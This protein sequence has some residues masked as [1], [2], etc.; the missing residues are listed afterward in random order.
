MPHHRAAPLAG[1]LLL[2]IGLIVISPV[3]ADIIIDEE[4]VSR[5]DTSAAYSVAYGRAIVH[6]SHT[7][8]LFFTD[9][10]RHAEL[11]YIVITR[12]GGDYGWWTD[13]DDLLAEGRHEFE[14]EFNG[15][16]RPGVLY[17]AK[18]RNLY[19]SVTKTE[20]TIFLNDW[21]ISGLT[22]PQTLTLPF[23][24][25]FGNK[26][27]AGVPTAPIYLR[28]NDGT[29]PGYMTF[30]YVYVSFS[31]SWINH[32]TVQTIDDGY[33]V[34][35]QRIF[36][37]IGSKS[38][39]S[40]L[41]DG[42]EVYTNTDTTDINVWQFKT[43]VNTLILID[44]DNNPHQFTLTDPGP[45]LPTGGLSLSLSPTSPTVGAPI[46]ASLTTSDAT[47][48]YSEIAYAI[49][50]PDGNTHYDIYSLDPDTWA[51]WRHYNGSSGQFDPSTAAAAHNPTF[52][53]SLAGTYTVTATIRDHRPPAT[54]ADLAAVS[55]SCKVTRP[56][57]NVYVY[58]RSAETGNLI[59]GAHLTITDGTTGIPIIN[60]I[61]TTGQK[62]YL[63]GQA[64]TL[65]YS[66]QATATGYT[67]FGPTLFGVGDDPLPLVLW[68]YPEVDPEDPP[69]DPPADNKTALYGYLLTQGSQQP[70]PGAT[71][72][73]DGGGTTT[74]SSAGFFL[75]NDIDPGS[76]ALTATATDHDQLQEQVTA[77]AAPT[78]HNMALKGHYTLTVTIKDA[79]SLSLITNATS[80]SLS[81]NQE[82]TANPAT[83]TVDY[84]AYTLTAAAEGYYPQV[85]SA[86]I[87]KP[88]TT[89]A[90]VLLTKQTEPP[91]V[92]RLSY[93]P[94]NVRFH[95]VDDYGLP[96]P[97]VAI[98]AEYLESTSPWSW[99]TD[100][101]GIPSSVEINTTTLA[102]TT[103]TDGSITFSMV[104]TIRY[105][106]HAHDPASNLTV[107][108]TLYP[109][110]TQYT[111]QFR[112]RPPPS[113]TT[114]PLYELTATPSEDNTE[115]TLAL[116]YRDRDNGT[117]SL[118]FWVKDAAGTTIHTSTPPLNLNAWTNT[119]HTVT[120]HPGSYTWGFDAT[121]N[122]S[123][124][125]TASRSITLH[126]TGR[127]VDLGFDDDFWYYLL[128]II[129]IVG[130]AAIFSGSRVRFGAIII[131]L[132]GGG[133]PTLIGWLPPITAPLIAILTF[134]G[135][136]VY[137][138]KSEYKMYR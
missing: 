96:L 85:Q 45:T 10:L 83:F 105:A 18:P 107:D 49:R 6:N 116:A 69:F 1:L 13:S 119:S 24:L 48:R 68:M 56:A 114:R 106:I 38:T 120:N 77:A 32:L 28:N 93:P 126:G 14:Y 133:I 84:G 39:L 50:D 25:H 122:I 135:V 125:I 113:T 58:V 3:S 65:R 89:Q 20:L 67:S 136:F 41:L 81:D 130:I 129:W 132:I 53:P 109:Q 101:L 131:P 8:T 63:L 92:D 29:A 104:E 23:Y 117:T 4:F 91:S 121:H 74:T 88:G 51:D 110:E 57:D 128:S 21:D 124:D 46:T 98:T 47:P 103:G 36:D 72:T 54:G 16:Y 12:A 60:E 66:A 71:V 99:L 62:T 87:D 44:W 7:D 22:G 94:H 115:V 137:M 111:I 138:R 9:I 61:L 75:F 82:S 112:T 34:S 15:E 43:A 19:G 35:L 86:Y 33:Y 52:I 134:I 55:A 78:Q 17:V 127:L 73:L 70:I 2:L 108:F 26:M 64:Y 5:T 42:S 11:S 123:G 100:L 118:T 76:Y 37:G 40:L 97:N 59:P 95:C 79:T 80:L 102:G 31:Y 30:D 90:T 27:T